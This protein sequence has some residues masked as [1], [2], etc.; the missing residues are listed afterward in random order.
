MTWTVTAKVDFIVFC[1]LTFGYKI[2]YR[3][4]VDFF[5]ALARDVC[6]WSLSSWEVTSKQWKGWLE[7][8][9]TIETAVP[10]EPNNHT[11]ELW[12]CA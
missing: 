10:N 1:R 9:M 11:Q 8:K 5:E 12:R 3:V 6:G 2:T 7:M 4:T